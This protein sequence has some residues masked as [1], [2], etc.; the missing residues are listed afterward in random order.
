MTPGSRT[1]DRRGA[2]S[3][4]APSTDDKVQALRAYRRARGECYTCG[5]RYSRGHVC[6][7]TVQ[8]HVVE[9]LWGLF[10]CEMDSNSSH[11]DKGIQADLCVVSAAA[12][13]GVEPPLTIRIKGVV[14]SQEVLMLI[15]SGSSHSFISEA[16]AAKWATVRRCR[17]MHVKVA[18]G[19]ILQCDLEVPDC[20]WKA[21]GAEF[22]T[23]LR[24]FPLGCYDIILGMDWL[25]GI[26]LMN[27]HWGLKRLSF[28]HRGRQVLLQGITANTSVCQEISISQ[29]E[30]LDHK[31]AICH[32]V[33]LREVKEVD[34]PEQCPPAIQALLS[35]FKDLF[36]EPQG[37]PPQRDFD[38]KITLLPGS[39]PV[40][41]RPYRYN[42]E[43]KNEIEKQIAEM[44]KQ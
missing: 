35:E 6:A 38:H 23:T 33:Q 8:L 12:Q 30:V 20:V 25:E 4:Q 10:G 19:G 26:G 16:T 3:A 34:Q 21:Q 2:A 32:L 31:H 9:E 18:D 37:L 5:E 1:E 42:P 17:P 28:Q 13:Q 40:N 36:A 43:Q 39:R 44:L 11:E 14:N 41:L 29:L 7:P 15:D 22:A 27:V 24:L